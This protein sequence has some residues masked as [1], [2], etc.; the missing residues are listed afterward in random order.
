VVE[1]SN[2]PADR[3]ATARQRLDQRLLARSLILT[4]PSSKTLISGIRMRNVDEELRD[5]YF[6]NKFKP[7]TFFMLLSLKVYRAY[8]VY[9]LE[10]LS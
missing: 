5:I 6:K 4:K 2:Q 3:R 1:G 9:F 7:V 8:E 10:H